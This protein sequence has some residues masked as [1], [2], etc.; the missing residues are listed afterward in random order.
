MSK[1]YSQDL[2]NS[3]IDAVQRG[4]LSRHAAAWRNEFSESVAAKWLEPVERDGS[5][6]PSGMAVTG[7]PS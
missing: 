7:R 1:P 3:M 5:R 2:R 6:E 4:E